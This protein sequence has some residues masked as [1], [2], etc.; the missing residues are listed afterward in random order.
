MSNRTISLDD[1]LY[2]YLLD[3]SLREPEV[4]TR[5]R[6]ET[7]LLDM[8]VMQISPEQGQFMQLLMKMLG[9]RRAIEVGVFT[10]YSSL[11]M[12]LAMPY[13]GRIIACDVNR[14]WTQIAQRYW[15][16]AGVA[17]KIDLQLAPASQT[18]EN[19]IDAGQCDQ[20]DFA[21]IDADKGN[22]LHY[23]ELCLQLIRPGGVIAIDNVL[24]SGDVADK[25]KND[26]DTC[27]IRHLNAHLSRDERVD[28]SMLPIG[29]GLTLA[30]RKNA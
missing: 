17:H 6:N 30:R 23:Y 18:L 3:H 28:V 19:L 9:V 2:Q 4:L 5:L 25:S 20:Y 7:A 14:E 11:C 27:A 1:H 16:L 13:E 29:D 26:A 24:W 12:A 15:Q 21:F 8:A 10:G 22:Y